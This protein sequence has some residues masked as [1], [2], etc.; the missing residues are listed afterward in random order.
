MTL[1][2]I[3]FFCLLLLSQQCRAEHP[4]F[5]SVAPE[6][7]DYA[8]WLRTEYNPFFQSVRDIPVKQLSRQWCYANEFVPEL[9]PAKYMQ[10][11]APDLSFSVES[12]FKQR[13]KLTAL[14]GA[15]ETCSHEKGL[16]ILIFEQQ[17][18]TK[19][20]RFLEQ[21]P[22]QQSLAALRLTKNNSLELWWCSGC[23]N[24]QELVWDSKQKKF[25]WN[26]KDG[27]GE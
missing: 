26:I 15:Y 17:K 8:W 20:V 24:Y 13:K 25:I 4:A 23:S 5:L 12:K 19:A 18:T 27:D 16:F 11:I 1:R 9:F 6:P 10:D 7:A 14:V 21:F 2:H 22:N 3:I